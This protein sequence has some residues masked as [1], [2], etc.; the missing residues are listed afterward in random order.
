[1]FAISS[2]SSSI[3]TC[4]WPARSTNCSP[5]TAVS[6]VRARDPG[7]LP[8]NQHVIEESHTD[9]QSVMLVRTDEPILDPSWSVKPVTMEDLVLAYMSQAREELSAS[10][11]RNRGSQ[12]IRF[13]ALQFRAQAAVAFIALVIAAVVLAITGPHLLHIYD[14]VVAT[15]AAHGDCS[16][17][18]SNF[19]KL[20]HGLQIALNIL[21]IVVPGI[22]GLFWGAPLVAHELE[23][24][25]FRLAWTQSVTRTRW[26]AVKIACVGLASMAV[27][28]LLSL[29]L[30]W[31]ASPIDRVNLNVFGTFDQRDIVP[32]GY[33]A[34]AFV[35]GRHRRCPDPAHP[36]RHGGHIGAVR[37]RQDR[38]HR[39]DTATLHD[40]FEAGRWAQPVDD[41]RLREHERRCTEPDCRFAEHSERLGL[42]EPDR[43]QGRESLDQPVPGQGLSEPGCRLWVLG[44]PRGEATAL[45]AFIP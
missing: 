30:T 10:Q 22:I 41:R 15:C 13:T 37:V 25:T 6:L 2:S 26:V 1:M 28:G 40:S 44:Q 7:S 21:I 3:H 19:V 32:I 23:A 17:V 24:R 43:R 45:S 42:L 16:S 9:K 5:G 27:A 4:G 31:W 29:M 39:L 11:V 14:T 36:S 33:A 34:F 38:R 8:Q 12:M 18:D 20:D 35:L